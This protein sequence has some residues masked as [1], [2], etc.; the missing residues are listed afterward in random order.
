MAKKLIDKIMP[1]KVIAENI[2]IECEGRILEMIGFTK[3]FA[4]EA[5][6]EK[7]LDNK[8]NTE[9]FDSNYKVEGNTYHVYPGKIA[10]ARAYS[11][12]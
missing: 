11:G 12:F 5:K 10:K 6:L 1:Y 4:K 9:V 8:I 2:T 7:Y 3:R